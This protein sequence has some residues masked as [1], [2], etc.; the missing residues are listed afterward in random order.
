MKAIKLLFFLTLLAFA[1]SCKKKDAEPDL[2]AFLEGK[3]KYSNGAE[4]EFKASSK[5]AVG[6]KI[7][8]TID[9][10]F[11]IGEDYWRNVLSTGADQW[12]FEQI[13]RYSDKV[14]VEYRKSTMTKKDEN[15]LSIKV[16][17][18]TDTELKRVDP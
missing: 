6:T 16:P 2:Y 13:V 9:Y 12:E 1:F 10:G 4:C 18:L 14:K 15:T 7:P 3:W 17:G 5:T 8:N 11:V